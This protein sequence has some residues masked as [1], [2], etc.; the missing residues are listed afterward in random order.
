MNSM[1]SNEFQPISMTGKVKIPAQ[2]TVRNG[3]PTFI[4]AITF[5]LL[6]EIIERITP[7][8]ALEA[9]RKVESKRLPEIG[10]YFIKEK[11]TWIFPPILVDTQE[12]LDFEPFPG[13]Q[14]IMNTD[15][16]ENGSMAYRIEGGW[17]I[18]DNGKKI[19]KIMD[20]QH[21]FM[22]N[23]LKYEEITSQLNKAK[24]MQLDFKNS[25]DKLNE[26]IMAN[27]IKTLQ[28]NY[29]RYANETLTVEIVSL[30]TDSLHKRW[31]TTVADK[32]E[33]INYSAK[34]RLDE[35]N[36]TSVAANILANSHPLFLDENGESNIEKH[37]MLAKKSGKEIYSLGNIRDWTKNIALG[38]T[39]KATF[40]READLN[41]ENLV[42]ITKVFLEVLEENCRILKDVSNH[43][44]NGKE[45]RQKSLLSSPTI[46]RALSGAFH[47]LCVH[48]S[49]NSEGKIKLEILAD[50]VTKFGKMVGQLNKY[51]DYIIVGKKLDV[52]ANWRKIGSTKTST[53]SEKD[54][55]FRSSGIA[56]Q[57][58]FQERQVLSD[59]FKKWVETE[60]VFEP[61]TVPKRAK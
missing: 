3:H 57:S 6:F 50:K 39:D 10:E 46:I 17:L 59:L 7:D 51:C 2:R 49:E 29:D 21:R 35:I 14:F 38:T 34:T 4:A 53:T 8:T 54:T 26:E 20:G 33:G 58:G 43:R 22:G 55:V 28:A 11:D 24:A 37:Q 47:E 60:T 15:N 13:Q 48:K 45:F 32:A 56:P 23:L 12:S 27:K 31:F 36:T 16:P 30:V 18:V 19:L 52:H 25:G 1:I 44:I 9:N 5:K 42:D 41:E 61:L 40:K